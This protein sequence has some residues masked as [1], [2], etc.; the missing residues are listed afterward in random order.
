[1]KFVPLHDHV[2]IK[3][4][5]NERKTT[6]GIVVVEGVESHY[7]RGVIVAMPQNKYYYHDR[8]GE[9]VEIMDIHVGDEVLYPE[10]GVTKMLLDGEEVVLAK[11]GALAGVYPK[12]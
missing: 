10:R 8:T 3:P 5:S 6:T 2:V 4:G 7:A 9:C 11:V 1:M 12:E